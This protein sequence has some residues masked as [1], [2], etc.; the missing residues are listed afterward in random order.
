[1][2][3]VEYTHISIGADG[4]PTLTGTRI[5]V[6]EIALDHLVHGWQAEDI[7]REFPQLSLGQIHSALGYYYD[8]QEELDADIQRRRASAEE[9]RDRLGNGPVTDALR[10]TRRPS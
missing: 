8:H 3:M 1:M 4:V 6:V 2:S 7:H 9:I 10:A 5:K